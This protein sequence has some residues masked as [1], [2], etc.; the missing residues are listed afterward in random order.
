MKNHT[1]YKLALA[2]CGQLAEYCEKIEIAG[3][4]RRARPEVNDIDLVCLPCAGR[5]EALRARIKQRTD[6]VSEGQHSLIVRLRGANTGFQL[7]V[8]FA[9]PRQA[10]LLETVPGTWGT[11]LLCRT[12]SKEHNIYLATKAR[13]LGL[14]WETTRGLVAD[15]DSPKA[16]VIA[17]ETEEE[18]FAALGMGFVPPAL[19]EVGRSEVRQEAKEEGAAV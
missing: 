10:D 19:R 9:K 18:I 17:S 1:A 12:G 5:E 4:I 11:V 7:D 3:S 16:R 2:C 14:K 8:W 13:E 6:V 15:P